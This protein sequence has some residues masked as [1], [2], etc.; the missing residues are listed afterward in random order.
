MDILLQFVDIVLH[1]DK[2]L[3]LLVQQYGTW[4][5]VILFAIIFSETGFVVTPFLPGDSLLFVAGAVAAVGGMD[6]A[7]LVLALSLAA[8]LGNSLNYAIGRY[9]GPRVFQWPDSR[10][11]NRSALD[12]THAFYERHGGKTLVLSRFLPLFRTFA[13]FVAGIGAMDWKRFTAFNLAGGTLW[14]V[15]LTLA[16]YWFGNLPLIRNNLSWVVVAIVVISLI[17]AAVGWWRHRR[18]SIPRA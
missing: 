1:L 15:S 6:I 5:Y 13:P 12:K 17:P 16:G 9:L 4:I 14:V 11:F 7:L 10:F 18:E 2:H 3:E 8:V